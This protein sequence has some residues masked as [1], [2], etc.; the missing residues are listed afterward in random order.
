M[1]AIARYIVILTF[2]RKIQISPFG[3]QPL[4]QT[5]LGILG[6]IVIVVGVKLLEDTFPRPKLGIN[7]QSLKSVGL[8]VFMVCA[9]FVR[10]M[11][12]AKG[13]SVWVNICLF[14]TTFMLLAQ[15]EFYLTGNLVAP[16]PRYLA[17]L[18][19]FLPNT[20]P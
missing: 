4:L 7:Y 18:T 11:P 15:Y 10:Q 17:H 13:F 6:V 2:G 5:W 3:F 12:S 8:S 20:I 1:R 9:T 14:F 16:P 19:N